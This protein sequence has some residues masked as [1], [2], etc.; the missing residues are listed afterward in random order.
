MNCYTFEI[1]KMLI[2]VAG[3]VIAAYLAYHYAVKRLKKESVENIERKK[4]E[5]VLNAHRQIYK[6]LAYTTDTENPKSILI[7]TRGKENNATTTYY[8]RK[9]NIEQF[10]QALSDQFYEQ[11][12][13]LFLS[14][15]V[16]KLLFEYRGIVYGLLLTSKTSSDDSIEFRKPEAAER[17]KNIHQQLSATIRESINLNKR[18][19]NEL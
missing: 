11:G 10:L 13:G 14:A 8:F 17:M 15:D 5:A 7:W 19:L 3:A 4:Y 18:D 1:L 6:L 2:P 9:R 16:N 12:N